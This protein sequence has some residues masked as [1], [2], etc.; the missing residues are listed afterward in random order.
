MKNLIF[1]VIDSLRNDFSDYIFTCKEDHI[2]LNKLYTHS[3]ETLLSCGTFL[4][5][6]YPNIHGSGSLYF[7]GRNI[8]TIYDYIGPTHELFMQVGYRPFGHS[9]SHSE[10]CERFGLCEDGSL[11]TMNPDYSPTLDFISNNSQKTFMV[12]NHFFALRAM[13][14]YTGEDKLDMYIKL[15]ER[16]EIELTKLYDLLLALDLLRNTLVVITSDHGIS[17]RWLDKRTDSPDEYS[18]NRSRHNEVIN[19]PLFIYGCDIP[20]ATIDI[21]V[22]QIDIFPSILNLLGIELKHGVSGEAIDFNDVKE[23][24]IFVFPTP[25]SSKKVIQYKSWK[26]VFDDQGKSLYNLDLNPGEKQIF[27]DIDVEKELFDLDDNIF[28]NSDLTFFDI[29]FKYTG[30]IRLDDNWAIMSKRFSKLKIDDYEKLS[31]TYDNIEGVRNTQYIEDIVFMLNP[32]GKEDHILDIGIGTG[33]VS[34]ALINYTKNLHGVDISPFMMRKVGPNISTRIGFASILPF[35]DNIFDIVFSRQLFHNLVKD[36]DRAISEVKRVLKPGGKFLMAEFIP[37]DDGFENE[38]NSLRIKKEE[39]LFSSFAAMKDL[40]KKYGFKNIKS[41]RSYF[42]SDLR[43]WI[44]NMQLVD[45][46][47]FFERHKSLLNKDYGK[48]C[49][50]EFKDNN[51]VFDMHYGIVIGEN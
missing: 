33:I 28:A 50:M 4:T 11:L 31:E 6:L 19:I 43:N 14:G 22:R 37:P 9:F 30:W 51:I 38:W 13:T 48:L 46:D 27:N 42:R 8:I 40:F 45:S 20:S 21:P 24:P 10:Y 44:D 23:K 26:L 18:T 3:P 41:F 39:R 1:I 47:E 17:I 15:H 49:N 34:K 35:H 2:R 29:I 16:I 32:I 12:Y 5:G 25:A 36:I 7:R